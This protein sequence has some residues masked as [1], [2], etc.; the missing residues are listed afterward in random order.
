MT[1]PEI[2]D[3]A[4][5][6]GVRLRGEMT[7]ESAPALVESLGALARERGRPALVIDLREVSYLDSTCLSALLEARRGQESHGGTL[8]VLVAPGGHVSDL[9]RITGTGDALGVRDDAEGPLEALL[10]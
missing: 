9:F 3:G 7:M 5:R 2:L 10:E 1:E 8:S 6:L 4:E